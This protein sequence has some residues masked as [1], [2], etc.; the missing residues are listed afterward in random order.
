[1]YVDLL[2]FR[3]NSVYGNMSNTGDQKVL[4]PIRLTY[5][6]NIKIHNDILDS[7]LE[8]SNCCICC[9]YN[10]ITAEV[11]YL[12]EWSMFID[13]LLHITLSIQLNRQVFWGCEFPSRVTA[14]LLSWPTRNNPE[15]IHAAKEEDVALSIVCERVFCGKYL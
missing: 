8:P 4:Q 6:S 12:W 11:N 15:L 3:F 9:V 7:H 14:C 5:F 13:S 1:M 2:A 10:L